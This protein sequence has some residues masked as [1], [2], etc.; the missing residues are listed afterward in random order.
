MHITKVHNLYRRPTAGDPHLGVRRRGLGEGHGEGVDGVRDAHPEECVTELFGGL[1]G[2][3]DE[4]QVVG[5]DG[6]LPRDKA[7]AYVGVRGLGKR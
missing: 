2:G 4:A 3:T 1:A 6:A 5:E 7:R